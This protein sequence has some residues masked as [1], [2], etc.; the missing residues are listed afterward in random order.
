MEY[1]VW[2]FFSS[3]LLTS[4]ILPPLSTFSL[5][6]CAIWFI[7]Y[8]CLLYIFLWYVLSM[9]LF[10][11][12]LVSFHKVLLWLHILLSIFCEVFAAL[13]YLSLD[14]L[15]FFVQFLCKF[16]LLWTICYSFPGGL[17]ILI[18]YLHFLLLW[19]FCIFYILFCYYFL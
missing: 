16:L 5:I 2:T 19:L 18:V 15:I 7:F 12:I 4:H 13:W 1:G 6:S 9:F 11:L 14:F 17:L 8:S 10:S 3:L